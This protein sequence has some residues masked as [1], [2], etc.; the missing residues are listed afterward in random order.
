MKCCEVEQKVSDLCVWGFGGR[1]LIGFLEQIQVEPLKQ[2]RQN[3]L[4]TKAFSALLSQLKLF[5]EQ[6]FKISM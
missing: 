3:P 6:T 2:G 1:V 5:P 4:E